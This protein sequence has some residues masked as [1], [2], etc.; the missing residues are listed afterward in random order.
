MEGLTPVC[1]YCQQF[2]VKQTGQDIY[3][4]RPDLFSKI[5]YRCA[6]CDAYVGTHSQTGKPLG[7][8]ANAKLRRLRNLAHQAFDPLWKEMGRKRIDAYFMLARG[9]GIPIDECH[10]AMFNENQCLETVNLCNSGRI[11]HYVRTKTRPQG[12]TPD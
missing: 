12:E 11:H 2:S 4:H 5:F 9:L 6:P 1:P 10:I 3:P 8:L 7:T